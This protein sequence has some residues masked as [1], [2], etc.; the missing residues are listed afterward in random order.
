MMLITTRRGSDNGTINNKVLFAT[1]SGEYIYIPDSAVESPGQMWTATGAKDITARRRYYCNTVLH[2][3][4]VYLLQDLCSSRPV[5]MDALPLFQHW[6]REKMAKF[7][8]L[9]LGRKEEKWWFP[10]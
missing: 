3:K 2:V 4:V 5:Y 9:A 1:A 8:F 6:G 10:S 7:S